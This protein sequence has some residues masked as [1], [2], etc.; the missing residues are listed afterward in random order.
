MNRGNEVI[1]TDH[2]ESI[3]ILDISDKVISTLNK[4]GVHTINDLC[5]LSPAQLAEIEGLG[6]KKQII[7]KQELSKLGRYLT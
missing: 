4:A 2:N 6:L 7:L 3:D 1:V 5:S